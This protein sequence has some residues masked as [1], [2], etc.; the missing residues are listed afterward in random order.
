MFDAAAVN[1]AQTWQGVP[2]V[3]DGQPVETIETQE[4]IFRV[5]RS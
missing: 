5:K 1:A 4:V 3:I 2:A